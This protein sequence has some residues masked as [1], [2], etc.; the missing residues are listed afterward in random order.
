LKLVS[1]GRT[2]IAV[3]GAQ[4]SDLLREMKLESNRRRASSSSPSLDNSAQSTEEKAR[5]RD[6]EMRLRKKERER[7]RVGFCD[8]VG[9]DSPAATGIFRVQGG[10]EQ[11]G[12]RERSG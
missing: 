6:G 3:V 4:P 2:Q 10:D 1:P 12:E 7:G 5:G 9:G 8:I 11:E